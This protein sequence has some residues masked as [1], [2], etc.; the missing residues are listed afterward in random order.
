MMIMVMVYVDSN[1]DKMMMMSKFIIMHYGTL[2]TTTMT[3][4][5]NY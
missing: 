4:D 5:G 2:Q 3:Q 1:D